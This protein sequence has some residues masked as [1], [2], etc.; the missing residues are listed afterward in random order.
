MPTQ[1]A[2]QKI[3][4]YCLIFIS[5]VLLIFILKELS[6][7]ILPFV[8]AAFL[9]LLL[10]P[11]VDLMKKKLKIPR[12][13]GIAIVLILTFGFIYL[14][15]FLIMMN[16]LQFTEDP[17]QYTQPL[18]GMFNNL[19]A[20][21]DNILMS[22]SRNT[23]IDFGHMSIGDSVKG[24][25]SGSIVGE[26]LSTASGFVANFFMVIFYWLFMMAGKPKFEQ[27][28]KIV[29]E[30][31]NVSYDDTMVVI[32]DKIQGYLSTKTLVNLA[33]AGATTILMLSF[34][35]DFAFLIGFLILAI[36]YIPNAGAVIGGTIP[37]LLALIQF[38]FGATFIIFFILLMIIQLGDAYYLE[39][40]M[41]ATS[42]RLS[43]V[44]VILAIV[45]WAYVWG[46]VG[47]FLAVPIASLIKIFTSN[48]QPLKPFSVLIGDESIREVK[49]K[50]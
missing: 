33:N 7:I 17:A 21:V 46:I 22:I 13:A 38:G 30:K 27:K 2:W 35:V 23:M 34:G 18:Q 16:I 20:W 8:I 49:K 15:G 48:I 36:N 45:F 11:L 39:P 14:V 37:A 40:T 32:K 24:L 41:M 9:A 4:A 42:L 25:F 31:K 5:L 12:W 50:L 28:L 29:L 47:A 10:D 43:P 1:T 26:S 6:G 44:Y 3:I 19:Q